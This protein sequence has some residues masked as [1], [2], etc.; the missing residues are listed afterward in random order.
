MLEERGIR[1][2]HLVGLSL[3]GM[4]AIEMARLDKQR[5]KTLTLINSSL[6]LKFWERLNPRLFLSLGVKKTYS[7][8]Y[9]RALSKFLLSEESDLKFEKLVETWSSAVEFH[10]INALVY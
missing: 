9:W 4:I 1:S 8:K 2:A 7:E 6:G 5:F 10:K 3:G